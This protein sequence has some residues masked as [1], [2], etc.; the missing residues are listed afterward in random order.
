MNTKA[1]DSC[2]ELFQ[3]MKIFPVYSQ[4]IY[5]LVLYTV[6]NKYLYNANKEIHKYRTRYN[7]NLHQSLVNLSKFNKGAYF[8]GI[9]GFNHLP[10]FI[11]ILSNYWKCFTPTLKSFLYQ[12]SFLLYQRIFEI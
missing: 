5:A 6:N 1:R 7:N 3:D 11:N 9:K 12:H 4:Y 2:K 10:E 8:S